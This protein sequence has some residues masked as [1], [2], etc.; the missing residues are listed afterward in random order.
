MAQVLE[1]RGYVVK[2][3]PVT[4]MFHIHSKGPGSLPLSLTG[5]FTHQRAYEL[6]ID[7]Y[8]TG[9]EIAEKERLKAEEDARL[10]IAETIAA[11]AEKFEELKVKAAEINA[12]RKSDKEH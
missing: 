4:T 5:L 6:V 9:Q 11:D 8:I 7:A 2:R 12:K 3:D 10:L 1:Y